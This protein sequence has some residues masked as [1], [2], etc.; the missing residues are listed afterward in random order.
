MSPRETGIVP[1]P[2]LAQ[3]LTA[4]LQQRQ[5]L[6]LTPAQLAWVITLIQLLAALG[7]SA[8]A[9]LPKVTLGRPKANSSAS[10]VA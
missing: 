4:H 7:P 5:A 8:M 10:E 9:V 6:G 3:A 1:N 2:E